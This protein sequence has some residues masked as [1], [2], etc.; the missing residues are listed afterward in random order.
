MCQSHPPVYRGLPS[1]VLVYNARSPSPLHAALMVNPLSRTT[2]GTRELGY[3]TCKIPFYL[4]PTC[5]E[6]PPTLQ[7]SPS[8]RLPR[9]NPHVIVPGLPT[10]TTRYRAAHRL[11]M[12]LPPTPAPTSHVTQ[13]VVWLSTPLRSPILVRD[14]LPPSPLAEEKENCKA[15]FRHAPKPSSLR[16]FAVFLYTLLS[17]P[18]PL[19]QCERTPEKIHGALSPGKDDRLLGMN[20]PFSFAAHPS[21]RLKVLNQDDAMDVNAKVAGAKPSAST[22]GNA[23]VDDGMV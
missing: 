6:S 10:I 3:R 23:F 11:P 2:N 19:W 21:P 7:H 9:P 4:S 14:F 22:I 12:F 17:L 16:M 1:C 8:N 20:L 5:H 13:F 15:L 18:I